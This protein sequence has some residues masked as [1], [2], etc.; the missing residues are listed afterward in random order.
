MEN[1][2]TLGN[3]SS[4]VPEFRVYEVGIKY[5]KLYCYILLGWRRSTFDQ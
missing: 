5:C 2:R 3:I 4:L 1:I